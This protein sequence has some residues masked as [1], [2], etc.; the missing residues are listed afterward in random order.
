MDRGAGPDWPCYLCTWSER[1]PE[2]Q[3]ARVTSATPHPHAKFV[4]FCRRAIIALPA[5]HNLVA[6]IDKTSSQ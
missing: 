3:S 1:L 4:D 5:T 2:D 6:D